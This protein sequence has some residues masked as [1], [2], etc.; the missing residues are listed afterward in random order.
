MTYISNTNMSLEFK[1]DDFN[2]TGSANIAS[3]S[4]STLPKFAYWSWSTNIDV[5]LS[6]KNLSLTFTRTF[7]SVLPNTW[8]TPLN[9]LL[10]QSR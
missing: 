2:V 7:N 4:N 3:T 1:E 10:Q 6:L 8:K 9:C 5:H